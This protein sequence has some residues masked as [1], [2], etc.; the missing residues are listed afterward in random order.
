MLYRA[1]IGKW[2]PGY[3][4]GPF[5]LLFVLL[6]LRFVTARFHASNWLVRMNDTGLYLHYRSYLNDQLP[7]DVPC[8]VFLSLG[9]IAS[10]RVVKERVQTSDTV[11]RGA[12]Q[13]QFLRYVELE[14][15]CDTALLAD[16]L[17]AERALPAP[18]TKR[19][20]GT[21]ST[22]YWDYPVSLASPKILRIRWDVVPRAAKFLDALRPYTVIADP[23]SA[24]KDFTHL[25]SLTREDQQKQLRELAVHGQMI[26]AVAAARELYGC[27]LGEAKAMI[28]SLA[29]P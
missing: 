8:I 19:W 11:E 7:A 26:A 23:V 12:T 16:A 29:R 24:A 4:F 3:I 21:S 9:E 15:S 17:Q 27:T 5:L 2:P 13:T 14:L 20:Y 22:L 18:Q 28:D 1:Y 25:K 10:A 6:T